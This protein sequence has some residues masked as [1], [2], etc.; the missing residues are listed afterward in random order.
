MK[1]LIPIFLAIVSFH[2]LAASFE[3]T[4]ITEVY[5]PIVSSRAEAYE[6]GVQDLQ[7]L[8]NLSGYQ[9]YRKLG[10]FST[11]VLQRTIEIEDGYI[12]VDEFAEA[13]GSLKYQA[14]VRVKYSF[15]ESGSNRR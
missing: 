7:A 2:S 12:V 3:Q 11:S 1:K 8:K 9:A 6:I 4:R 13:D 10:L 5:T 15:Q 14:K